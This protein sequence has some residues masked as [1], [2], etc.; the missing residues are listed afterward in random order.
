VDELK[1]KH[2]AVEARPA[3]VHYDSTSVSDAAA[4]VSLDDGPGRYKVSLK[5]GQ[6]SHSGA[7]TGN[8][9]FTLELY[10]GGSLEGNV[11][12]TEPATT[13]E[14]KNS[15]PEITFILQAR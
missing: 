2:F 13:P 8:A 1:I 7:P 12:G 15:P 3:F 9:T 10:S 11:I 14:G 4:L 5:E 6:F